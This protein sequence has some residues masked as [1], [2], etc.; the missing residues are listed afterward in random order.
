[1]E[2]GKDKVTNSLDLLSLIETQR[3]VRLIK[4]V[5]LNPQQLLIHHHSRSHFLEELSEEED[6]GDPSILVG[7]TPRGKLDRRLIKDMLGVDVIEERDNPINTT[8]V[9]LPNSAIKLKPATKTKKTSELSK[10][11]M[12]LFPFL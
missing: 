9:S 5:L 1:M 3:T 4:S 10:R 12:R 8:R 7:Y 11:G 2:R 6:L